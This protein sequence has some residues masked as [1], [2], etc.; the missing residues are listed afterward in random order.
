LQRR[1]DRCAPTV[2]PI[3]VDG[4]KH[5]ADTEPRG[6]YVLKFVSGFKLLR[7]QSRATLTP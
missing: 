1:N 3:F 2:D 5:V 7:H 4:D 6:D